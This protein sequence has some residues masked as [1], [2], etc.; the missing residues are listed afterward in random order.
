MSYFLKTI[1][2]PVHNL[3][4]TLPPAVPE[5]GSRTEAFFQTEGKK[6]LLTAGQMFVCVLGAERTGCSEPR[7]CT[8]KHPGEAVDTSRHCLLETDCHRSRKSVC[9]VLLQHKLR[10]PWPWRGPGRRIRWF[11]DSR[12]I[13]TFKILQTRGIWPVCVEMKGLFVCILRQP[14]ISQYWR[15]SWNYS[16]KVFTITTVGCWNQV[17]GLSSVE[18]PP[19]LSSLRP[20]SIL[21]SSCG[22][23][24]IQALQRLLLF[25]YSNAV[26]QLCSHFIGQG[27][28]LLSSEGA[29]PRSADAAGQVSSTV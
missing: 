12:V 13:F 14:V 21:I 24:A 15:T 4:L 9:F 29:D 2:C 20:N 16:I 19:A 3:T 5:P 18:D 6:I 1:F 25:F 17:I 11:S 23:Y 22:M 28:H 26:N 10:K 8:L 27:K 7:P